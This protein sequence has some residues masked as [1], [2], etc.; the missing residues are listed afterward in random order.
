MGYVP[1]H[2]LSA[3]VTDETRAVFR[4]VDVLVHN[5]QF[6]PSEQKIADAYG[7]ST[8]GDVVAFAE[9][10]E[11]GRLV[12]FHHGP[13][14]TDDAIDRILDELS[15]PMPVSAARE[16]DELEVGPPTP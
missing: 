2:R 3:G 16:G 7:H 12:L 15:A 1:D 6:L 10:C 8:L 5:A 13:G 14:R 11:V 9:A 4:G